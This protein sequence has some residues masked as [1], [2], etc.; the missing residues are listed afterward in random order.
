[1]LFFTSDVGDS[2]EASSE[3]VVDIIPSRSK[4]PSAVCSFVTCTTQ[5]ICWFQSSQWKYY[6]QISYKMSYQNLSRMKPEKY[7]SLVYSLLVP[8]KYIIL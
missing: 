1:M 6:Q 3:H 4:A 7:Y 8:E 5:I 2:K